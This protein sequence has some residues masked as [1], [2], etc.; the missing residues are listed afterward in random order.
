MV[1]GM[2]NAT[3]DCEKMVWTQED[4]TGELK[5]TYHQFAL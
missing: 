3:L 2:Y 5:A 4:I 1:Q